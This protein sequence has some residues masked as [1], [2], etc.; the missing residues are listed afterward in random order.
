MADDTRNLLKETLAVLA[1]NDK[2]ARDVRWVGSREI[3]TTWEQ[4]AEIAEKTHYDAGFGG[5]EIAS[6]LLVVGCDWWLERHEYDGSE[7]WEFKSLPP[8][9]AKARPIKTLAGCSWG[10]LLERNNG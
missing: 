1:K 5:Q 6:D 7:W 4:F 3:Y 2:S 8:K 9:P 10:S